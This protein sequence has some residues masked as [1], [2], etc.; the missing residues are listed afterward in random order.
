MNGRLVAIGLLLL[1]M[2]VGNSSDAADEPALV[3]PS[4][5]EEAPEEPVRPND[6]NAL[7]GYPDQDLRAH[8]IAPRNLP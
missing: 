3:V 5:A 1:V 2:W 8:F 7:L 4:V 6:L